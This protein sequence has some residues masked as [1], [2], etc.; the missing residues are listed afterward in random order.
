M[1]QAITSG[2]VARDRAATDGYAVRLLRHA[3]L[4]AADHAR[5]ADL[6]TAAGSGNIFAEHWFMDAALRHSG[7]ARDARLAIVSRGDGVWQGVLPLKPEPRFGRWPAANWQSWAATNQFLGSPLVRPGAAHGF[8]RAL[9]R[10]LDDQTD[11]RMLLH[12]RQF[13]WDDPTCAALVDICGEGERGFRL[14]DRFDRPARLPGGDVVPDGKAQARLRSLR[15][16]LEREHGPVAIDM[17]ASAGDC[18]DW[19]DQF[20]ALEK[21]GWKGQAG[22]ALA[23][24]PETEGLF[25]EVIAQGQMRGRARLAALMAGG[26]PIAM[27]SWFV[28]GDHGFGFK[29]AFDEGF[30]TYAPGLLLMRHIADRIGEHPAM[31]F[32]TCTPTAGGCT[33]PLWGGHRTIFECAVAVGPPLRRLCF[34]ALM[35]ARAAYSAIMPG[36]NRPG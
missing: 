25:R 21:S 16:R 5:W 32:D 28:G 15:R 9:L 1:H 6:S 3:E 24:D 27:S 12:C 33:R 26:R 30:R 14:L 31:V 8:W 11:G 2:H 20:L 10:H 23:C 13:A 36:P 29:M 7:S 19:I 34:D 4:T 35:H 22:S 18:G 17:Q